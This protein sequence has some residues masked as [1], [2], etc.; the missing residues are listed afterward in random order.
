MTTVDQSML[1]TAWTIPESSSLVSGESETDSSISFSASPVTGGKN[2]VFNWQLS[3]R[4]GTLRS[5]CA[6]RPSS[7]Y[8]T[9]YCR[10]AREKAS[11]SSVWYVLHRPNSSVALS[12][13]QRG[14]ESTMMSPLA[15]SPGRTS[16]LCRTPQ[17]ISVIRALTSI[18]LRRSDHSD[19]PPLRL[20]ANLLSELHQ[21]QRLHPLRDAAGATDFGP[22]RSDGG[23]TQFA[24][25]SLG[26]RQLG[27][28]TVA[29]VFIPVCPVHA[30][31]AKKCERPPAARSNG[32]TIVILL[33]SAG[34]TK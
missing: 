33:G 27:R 24:R 1:K 19:E 7:S 9:M 3:A 14:A 13:V 23:S 21:D 5:L 16:E 30:G 28:F 22:V 15:S 11:S 2:S 32:S 34:S 10:S 20:R 8:F 17:L 6:R 25:W 18:F 29:A 4:P 12:N 26:L 31:T